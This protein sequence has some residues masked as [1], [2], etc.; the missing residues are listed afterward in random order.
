MNILK[1][2]IL[3]SKPHIIAITESWT[4]KDMTEAELKIEGYEI[5]GRSD[6]EDTINGRGGGVLLYSNLPNISAVSLQTAFHQILAVKLSNVGEDDLN[7]QVVYRSP[8]SSDLNNKNL[9]KHM[10]NLSKNTIVIGDF[11]CPEINW[12]TLTVKAPEDSISQG[13]LNVSQDKFLEQYVNFPTNFTPQKNETI[14]ETCIDLILTDNPDIVANVKSAGHLAKSK[15]AI[16]EAELMIPTSQNETTELVPDFGKADFEVIR[17]ALAL[18][19]WEEELDELS[20]ERSWELFKDKVYKVMENSIPKKKRRISNRPLWMNQNI[21]RAIRKKRRVWKWYCTTRDYQ[22][23]LSYQKVCASATKVVRKAKRRL[24]RKLAKN[25]KSNPKSFY[26][27]LNSCTK[28]RSKVGPL[29]DT[30]GIVQTDDEVMTDILNTAYSS[31]FTVEDTSQFPEVEQLYQGDSPLTDTFLG[32]EVVLKKINA[33]DPNKTPGPDKFHPK[34]LKEVGD[35]L[36]VPLSIIFTKSLRERVVP[37]DWRTANVVSIFKKGDRTSASNYRP[38]SLTSVVCK[39]LESILKDAIMEHLLENELLR[40]SQHGFMPLR[41]CLTNLLEFLE[42]VTKL[43]DAGHQ[44][45]LMYLDFS[46]AFDKVPHRRLLMKVQSLGIRGNMA[47]W[48]EAWLDDRQ[49]RTVLNGRFSDWKDVTSGVPQGSVLGPCL[50]IIYIN[51]IE[52]AID[53]IMLVKKFADDTKACGVA[54]K[55]EDCENLQEQVDKL[56]Q[57]SMDW[58]MLFNKEKCKVIHVGGNSLRYD[59][60]LGPDSLIKADSEKDLG[61]YIHETLCPSM[62]IAEAVKTANKKLGQL[63]RAVSYRDR[64]NFVTL[65]RSH[66]RCH[67]EYCVQAWSPWLK[68]DIELLEAVQKR[69]VRCIQGLSG[70]YE[71]KL[72]QIGLPTLV[73]RRNRGDMIQTFK[74]VNQI[75]NVDP[76]TWFQ[77]QSDTHR[78]LRGNTEIADDGNVRK[79]LTLKGRHSNTELRRNFFSNRVIRPWNELPESLRCEKSVN[80]FKNGYDDLTA[81]E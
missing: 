29:K 47:G 22:D 39:M 72:R 58:Q 46:R 59:Y 17:N 38:I 2:N 52:A 64:F 13:L 11:N 61:V 57:W 41:S 35:I 75:D 37:R 18:I 5:V 20:T 8:N 26:K 40:S 3:E 10:S 51:D 42:E 32:P 25:I 43:V 14:T 65:Y 76:N 74:I 68:K 63:I 79:K 55:L 30:N 23:Y 28:T 53:T 49:Q 73:D 70:T 15:H 36:S 77:F 80:A 24:E 44:V 1:S 9:L 54:D 34:F 6:R 27:Y 48:I 60:K 7:L 78:P 21:M 62:H 71:E 12:D 81:V 69:A 31:V 67:L 45:D 19:R 50:F 16:I 56:Y 33:L 4:H 66:V